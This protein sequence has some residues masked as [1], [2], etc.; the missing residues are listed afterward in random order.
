MKLDEFLTLRPGDVIVAYVDINERGEM[1]IDD[2]MIEPINKVA[3]MLLETPR[4]FGEAY[5][6]VRTDKGSLHLQTFTST[7]KLPY[8]KP[9]VI[10]Q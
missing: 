5:I 1:Y 3:L 10:F 6:N 7:D 9:I 4:D 8:Q 2:I